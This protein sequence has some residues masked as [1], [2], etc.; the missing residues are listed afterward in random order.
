MRRFKSRFLLVIICLMI[1]IPLAGCSGISVDSGVSSAQ[2]YSYVGSV[3][4]DIYHNPSCQWAQKIHSE[5]EIW[6][7]SEDDARSNGYRAC[8]VCRP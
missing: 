4:S 6:F 1:I 2:S 3:N 7:I 8:K 5:N